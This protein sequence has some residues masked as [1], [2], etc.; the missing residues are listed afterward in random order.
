MA[1]IDKI[2][3]TQA[4]YDEFHAWMRK[5]KPEF[6]NYFYSRPLLPSGMFPLTNF[7]MWVDVWLYNNC[8]LK[9]VQTEIQYQ[10]NGA[11]K[12][13]R[14]ELGDNPCI[15]SIQ[16]SIFT[17]D[18]RLDVSGDFSTLE[19]LLAYAQKVC[20]ILNASDLT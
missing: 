4:Q 1:G 16:N 18:A 13:W 9:W 11:P 20:D 2:Y 7:P 3:G 5:E 6:L 12:V 8:P 17:H 19:E 15:I 14:V 10:Y